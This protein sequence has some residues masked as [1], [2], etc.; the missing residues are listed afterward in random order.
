MGDSPPVIGGGRVLSR[1]IELWVD[2]ER[3][4]D[5]P[6]EGRYR[7]H[8]VLAGPINA[9]PVWTSIVAYGDPFQAMTAARDHLTKAL[10][11]LMFPEDL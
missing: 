1:Q 9:V 7:A 11:R 8:V 5:E 3:I 2:A 10:S 4:E 6:H